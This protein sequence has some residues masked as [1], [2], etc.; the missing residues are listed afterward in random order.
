MFSAD[1]YVARRNRLKE[2]IKSGL[3]L[4]LGNDESPM[5]YA[6]NTYHFRQ[7]STFLY[8]FG[9][10]FAGLAAVI[11]L[12]DGTETIFGTELTV[13]DIVW[14]GTQPTLIEKSRLVGVQKTAPAARLAEMLS[15]AKTSGRTVHFLPPYRPENKLKLL[16]LL[17]IPPAQA[18]QSASVEFIRAVV[19]QRNIKSAEEIAEI[20]RASD[21]SVDMHVAAMTAARPGMKEYELVAEVQRVAQAAGCGLAFPIILTVNG[22]TLHNH[23]HGNTLKNGDLV[24]C[25][26][27]AETARHYAADLSSSFPVDPVFSPRQREI[28]GLSLDAYNAAVA[29]LKPGVPFRD[30]HL[31]ACRVIAR[32]LKDLGLM[33][34]D[35][36]EAV[37]Q[38]AH[39]MFFPCGTGHMMGLDVHDMED[40]GEVYV[41]YDGEPKSTQ[42]GLKSLRLARPL[43]P[44]FV[45]T[46]EP[47]IYFIPELMDKWHS[48][49]KFMDFLN[50]DKMNAYRGF[51]GVRN[52]ESFLITTEGCRRMGKDKPKSIEDVEA[53]RR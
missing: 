19:D 42:F 51:S 29:M 28:Y 37:A 47:G 40:L 13:E 16:D 6:D 44:G 43:E 2:R 17:G 12:D 36:D 25:D 24:L 45:L 32:G 26:F 35:V 3:L 11:D 53:L 15:V 31:T 30:V 8:Y 38:G 22:Q 18:A 50:Y 27:G 4:F 5:N 9:L 48:E 49:G 14:M 34:G 41:G 20:D 46:V 39:A 7:D 1:I 52:E 10:D 23:Y 33:K 21:V